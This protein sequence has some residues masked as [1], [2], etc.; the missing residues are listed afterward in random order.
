[1]NEEV[2]FIHQYILSVLIFFFP[3]K[4]AVY[5]GVQLIDGRIWYTYTKKSVRAQFSSRV[6]A[7]RVLVYS[8]LCGPSCFALNFRL[9][10]ALLAAFSAF[11]PYVY[12]CFSQVR[13]ERHE[14]AEKTCGP[15][16]VKQHAS[17][18]LLEISSSSHYA[19]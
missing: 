7:V 12:V 13:K 1:M 19:I 3:G 18:A 16:R 2:H 14:S 4:T 11:H 5:K 17:H 9:S 10:V 6:L 8:F 15:A